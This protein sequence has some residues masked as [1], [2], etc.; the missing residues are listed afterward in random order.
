MERR[1]QGSDKMRRQSWGRGLRVGVL[2]AALVLLVAV[3]VA[4]ALSGPTSSTTYVFATSAT[5]AWKDTTQTVPIVVVPS[6]T[7]AT[8]TVHFSI[9]GGAT[10][11]TISALTSGTATITVPVISEGSHLFRYFAS[12]TGTSTVEATSTGD[13]YVNIDT[14]APTTTVAPALADGSGLSPWFNSAVTVTLNST[15]V[16]SGVPA[17]GT[18]Y[19][20]NDGNLTIYG[21]PFTV[22]AVGSTKLTYHSFDR[23]LNVEATQTAWVNIDETAPTVTAKATPTRSSGWYNVNVTVALTP[24]DTVSGVATTQYRVQGATVWTDAAGSMFKVPASKNAKLTYDYQAVDKAGNVSAAASLSLNMD[25]I[26]PKTY[27]QNASGKAGKSITLK[28]KIT[29]N[30]SPQAQSV[31]LKIKNSRGQT[32]MNQT[33]SGKKKINTWYSLSWKPTKKGIYK[34][35]VYAKDLAGNQQ[36]LLGSGKIT[37]K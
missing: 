35:Y 8:A 11:S 14:V 33:I 27:G 30:L 18:T 10:F 16:S 29:D 2:A 6:E 20:I 31:W 24:T 23:A 4:L 28:Y 21:V 22:S 34:Y 36:N 7:S 32:V 9:D 37:V 3:P 12:D 25:S 5:T 15:D 13:T 1:T 17:G 26:P 19:R